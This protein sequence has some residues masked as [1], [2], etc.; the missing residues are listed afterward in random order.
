MMSTGKIL[1]VGGY[2]HVGSGIARRLAAL[3]PGRVSVGGRDIG[4]ATAAALAVGHGAEGRVVDVSRNDLGVALE[5]VSATVVC[6]DQRDTRFVED[7]LSRGV[8]YVDIS[9]CHGFLSRVEGLDPVARRADSTAVL[10]V[11]VAPGLTNLLAARA[12]QHMVRVDRLDL[13]VELGVGDRHGPAAVEWMLENLDARFEVREG[14]QVRSVRSFG[15]AIRLGFPGQPAKSAYRFDFPDQHVLSRTLAIPEV[16]TWVRFASPMLTWVMA[17][18]AL[19]G[20]GRRSSWVRRAVRRTFRLVHVGS[21]RCAVAVRARG[22][23]MDGD[24]TLLLGLEGRQ[25]ARMTSIVAAE[26]V[27]QVLTGDLAPG[28]FHSEQVISFEPVIDALQEQVGGIR[29][30]ISPA[31]GEVPTPVRAAGGI[32]R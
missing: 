26:T 11:G 14:G 18:L 5:D 6:I 31:K 8:H 2:G 24:D 29:V 9:A 16:S 28:V 27:R 23:T 22:V 20:I 3:F 7:C 4:R 30:T 32:G 10:S 21:D 15:E 25:E 12:V 13:L 1:I 19:I 17:K